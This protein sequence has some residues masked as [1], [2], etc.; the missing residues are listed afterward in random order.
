MD[1]TQ[2]LIRAYEDIAS[3]VGA[4]HMSR[5]GQISQEELQ[6]LL[7]QVIGE[8]SE[9]RRLVFFLGCAFNKMAW[10][11]AKVADLKGVSPTELLTEDYR[12]IFGE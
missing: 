10:L 9:R 4:T 3:L 5:T 12:S 2:E 11:H 6:N 7:N 1:E 8:W